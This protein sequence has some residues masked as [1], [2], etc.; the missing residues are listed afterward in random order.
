MEIVGAQ[1]YLV[2][3]TVRDQLLNRESSERDWVVV[4]AS[5]EQM[6]QLGFTRVGADFP[7]FLHP[8]SR[9]E[10][11][12]ARQER[13]TGTGHTGF[14]TRVDGVSLAEDLLRRDL[15]INAMARTS[16]GELIDPYGGQA[17]LDRRLLRHVSPAFREDPLRVLRVA[18]FM[19]Q[20]AEFDFQ[21]APETL[22]LMRTMS[23]DGELTSLS[24]ERIWV[25][26][27]KA[28]RA[29][30]P[31]LFIETLRSAGA[32]AALFPEID[33]L[34]GVPQHVEFHPEIDTGLHT[35]LSMDRICEQTPDPRQRFAVLLHDIGK[36]STPAE[37][38]PRHFG[39]ESRGAELVEIVCRRIRVPDQYRKLA[40]AVARYH[41]KCHKALRSNAMELEALLSSLGAWSQNSRLDAFTACCMADARGRTGLEDRPYPQR[42]F[43]ADCVRAGSSVSAKALIA[44][45]HSGKAVGVKLAKLRQ[46]KIES[47]MEKYADIDELSIA[48]SSGQTAT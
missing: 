37:L 30:R 5:A 35:L 47:V 9:E 24:P 36:G 7:V 41:L 25:E 3:G 22:D 44:E 1:V 15:S 23:S 14:S 20:L 48:R 4:G 43:L 46:A 13:K 18:R 31:R 38:L 33:R 40:T 16:S 29:S 45:G 28:L 34:F 8:E 6:I 26:T 2:G 21:V 10:Y 39:H 17:D 19:A 42:E 32:L 12:L 27:E 11:A